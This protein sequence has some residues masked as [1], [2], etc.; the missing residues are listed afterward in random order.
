MFYAQKVEKRRTDKPTKEELE[1]LW[2]LMCDHDENHGAP[3]IY[4]AMR[5]VR[6]RAKTK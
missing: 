1:K 2:N 6:N 5:L 3:Q 4:E